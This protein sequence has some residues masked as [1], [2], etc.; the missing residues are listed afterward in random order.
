M[1]NEKEYLDMLNELNGITMQLADLSWHLQELTES[2]SNSFTYDGQ[3]FNE[4]QHTQILKGIEEGIDV[5]FYND[6]RYDDYKM[7]AI[8]KALIDKIPFKKEDI[9][10][11]YNL[12]QLYQVFRA[13]SKPFNYPLLSPSLPADIMSIYISAVES[14]VDISP[15]INNFNAEQLEVILYCLQKNYDVNKLAI[16]GMSAEQMQVI[17]EGLEKNVDVTQFN[18]VSLSPDE[19][20]EEL[21]NF[22][23]SLVLLHYDYYVLTDNQRSVYENEFMTYPEA[24]S[25]QEENGGALGVI[26]YRLENKNESAEIFELLSKDNEFNTSDFNRLQKSYERALTDKDMLA[27]ITECVN[28]SRSYVPDYIRNQLSNSVIQ[29]GKR[30]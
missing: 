29:G 27:F 17:Y 30:L 9:T 8:R 24:L 23:A 7:A 4:N 25:F 26:L 10:P 5:S 1:V 15:Y 19:M 22:G 14:G 16:A 3:T 21:N 6:P 12:A 11:N 13:K 20:R 18:D 28:I 2:R